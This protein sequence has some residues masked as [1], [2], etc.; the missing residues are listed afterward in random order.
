MNK[1]YAEKFYRDIR[2][3]IADTPLIKSDKQRKKNIYIL[4]KSQGNIYKTK[5]EEERKKGSV[6]QLYSIPSEDEIRIH[7]LN[8]MVTW[9]TLTEHMSSQE[10]GIYI[11]NVVGAYHDSWKENST[12]TK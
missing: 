2:K 11:M 8:S 3:I 9:S 10:Y 1:T 4:I 12:L 5:A 6:G 7:V